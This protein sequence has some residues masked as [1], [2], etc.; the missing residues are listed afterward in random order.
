VPWDQSYKMLMYISKSFS[1]VPSSGRA[2][3][4]NFQDNEQTF[5]ISWFCYYF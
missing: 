2:V 5:D 1:L 4:L 3:S